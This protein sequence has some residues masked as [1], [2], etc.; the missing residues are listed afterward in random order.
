MEEAGSK[1]NHRRQKGDGIPGIMHCDLLRH[2]QMD[3]STV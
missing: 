2:L 3:I 1:V